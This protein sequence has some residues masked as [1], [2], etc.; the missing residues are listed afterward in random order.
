MISELRKLYVVCVCGASTRELRKLCAVCDCGELILLVDLL[1]SEHVRL[2]STYLFDK[3][4]YNSS[5]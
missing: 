4:F 2:G 1:I 5:K 3:A